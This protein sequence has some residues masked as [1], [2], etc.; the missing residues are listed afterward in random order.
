MADESA[1]RLAVQQ[2]CE[3]QS[4]QVLSPLLGS[5]LCD[6]W[7]ASNGVQSESPDWWFRALGVAA[8]L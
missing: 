1:H 5:E 8:W 6:F 4:F 3:L 2:H 7:R